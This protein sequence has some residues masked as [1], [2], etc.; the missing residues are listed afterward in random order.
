MTSRGGEVL[1]SSYQGL[2]QIFKYRKIKSR[3]FGLLDISFRTSFEGYAVG[4]SGSVYET[5][6]CGGTWRG[7][8]CSVSD[9]LY[10][11]KFFSTAS[12]FILGND[13]ILMRYTQ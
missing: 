13:G 3:G 6:D 1:T 10:S 4:G 9:N 5:R 2:V 7:L 11:V 8:K 12:G